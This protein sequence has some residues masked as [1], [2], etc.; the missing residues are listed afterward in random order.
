MK[1]KNAEKYIER[2]PKLTKALEKEIRQ[3]HRKYILFNH[4]NQA[5]C[6]ACEKTLDTKKQLIYGVHKEKGYCPKCGSCV[7]EIDVTKSYSG[8]KTHDVAFAVVY[9]AGKDGN[10]YARCFKQE[11]GFTHGELR[12][13]YKLIETQRYIFAKDGTARF[14]FAYKYNNETGTY[15]C[16]WSVCS[17]VDYPNFEDWGYGSMVNYMNNYEINISAIEKTWLKYSAVDE[18][19]TQTHTAVPAVLY[20]KFWAKH[21]GAE[22]LVK[23]GFGKDIREMSEHPGDDIVKS[24]KWNETEVHKML[25]INRR[26]LRFIRNNMENKLHPLYALFENKALFPKC[27]IEK[28]YEFKKALG[29]YS[30]DIKTVLNLIG[31]DKVPKLVRYMKKRVESFGIY[32]DYI[33]F[34][35]KLGYDLSS[36]E[37]LFPPHLR[38]AHD[39]AYSAIEAERLAIETRIIKEITK[40][41]KRLEFQ[42]KDLIIKLPKDPQEIIMEGQILQHCVA[43]YAKRHFEGKT[44]ILFVRKSADVDKPYFTIE[45]DNDYSMVQCHGYRNEWGSEKPAEIKELETAYKKHLLKIKSSSKKQMKIG[46]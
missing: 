18:F 36:E 20:L 28:A 13:W 44:T 40:K 34:C 23:C 30:S 22:R 24:I 21:N 19:T 25:G 46:A 43:G 39:R 41:R 38:A 32:K 31:H 26:E 45:V 29:G 42:F 1:D 8:R 10:L 11:M 16:R 15:D 7:T 5:F 3:T 9:F 33:E 6:T 2:F 37:I 27:P 14:R 4:K 17:R 35:R 12:P